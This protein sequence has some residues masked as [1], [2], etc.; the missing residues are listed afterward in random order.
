MKIQRFRGIG[1][2]F[3]IKVAVLW[4]GLM[5]QFK[6]VFDE[7]STPRLEYKN[8]MGLRNSGT[9]PIWI[10]RTYCDW[11]WH[12]FISQT[13]NYPIDRFSFK[14]CTQLRRETS[15]FPIHPCIGGRL[16]WL[17]FRGSFWYCF[18]QRTYY[19][20]QV[21]INTPFVGT[22]FWVI[23]EKV[24]N[25]PFAPIEYKLPRIKNL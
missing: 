8:P 13:S 5:T 9:I 11:N 21:F 12:S 7:F 22:M 14:F 2:V 19:R 3:H 24:M 17:T 25:V 10:T 18:V 4:L 16:A 20:C 15:I 23:A 6:Y 1:I